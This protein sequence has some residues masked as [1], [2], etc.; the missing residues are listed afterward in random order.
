MSVTA[1]W[2]CLC[3]ELLTS[4]PEPP[5]LQYCCHAP[6]AGYEG[7]TVGSSPYQKRPLCMQSHALLRLTVEAACTPSMHS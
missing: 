3:S 4:A 1:Q 2:C 7:P 5:L 6:P